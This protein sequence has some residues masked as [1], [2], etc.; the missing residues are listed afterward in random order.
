MSLNLYYSFRE[1]MRGLRRARIASMVTVSTIA[2]TLILLDL[3]M[4]L[5]LNVHRIIRTFKAQMFLEVFIDN[6]LN[7][8]AIEILKQGLQQIEGVDSIQYISQEQ[9]LARF[10][11]EFG[12]D[13]RTLLG[14]NPL[15]PSFQILLKPDYRTPDHA[16]A[17]ALEI[18]K[19]RFVNEVVYH[20]R[21]YR[22]VEK[23]S[24]IVFL[25]DLGLVLLVFAA[26]LLLVANTLRLT[27]MAQ[28][29]SIQIMKL[30][31]ATQ[32]FIRRPYL[33]QGVFQ[34]SLGGIVC[35]LVIWCAAK[36][37]IWK[38]SLHPVGM[39]FYFWGPIVLGGLLGFLG[40]QLGL[41]RHL[42]T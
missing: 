37:I 35:A 29:K 20:G 9:A 18:G 10:A 39:S 4:M 8:E 1:G 42:N 23:Y 5:T 36:L 16:D 34:G 14:E 33:I 41:R 19:K 3:F 15:P 32:N 26:A 7:T 22:M 17:V 13:P 2:I 30:I 27:I 28:S 21:F 6:T 38:F 40:S 24:R 25:V 31:G 11:N 12:E